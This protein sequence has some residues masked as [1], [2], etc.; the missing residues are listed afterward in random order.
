[1][2][3]ARVVCKYARFSGVDLPDFAAL[4]QLPEAGRPGGKCFSE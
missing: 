2:S 4:R 1:L 3:D